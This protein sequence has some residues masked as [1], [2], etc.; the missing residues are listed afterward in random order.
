[1]PFKNF[2]KYLLHILMF[3]KILSIFLYFEKIKTIF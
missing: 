3:Q 1:V 2:I